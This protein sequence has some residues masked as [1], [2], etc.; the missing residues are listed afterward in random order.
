MPSILLVEDDELLRNMY[1]NIFQEKGY[2]V[3]VATDGAAALK[4]LPKHRID[5]ILLDIVL[6]HTDGLALLKQFKA[7]PDYK[8]IPVVVITSLT[9]TLTADTA[10]R[11]GATRF[12]Q[13]SEH[14]P[15]EVVTIV[16]EALAAS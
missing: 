14:R 10:M 7:S 3:S 9:D 12:I 16:A 4:I 13:K 5:I 1:T 15:A 6:P 2:H 11:D 8:H